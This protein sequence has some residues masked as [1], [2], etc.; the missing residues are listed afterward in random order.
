MKRIL[1][2]ALLTLGVAAAA[3]AQAPAKTTAPAPAAASSSVTEMKFF[4]IE[5]SVAMGYSIPDHTVQGGSSFI[6]N[7]AVADNM[8]LGIQALNL[9]GV[10]RTTMKFGYYLNDLLGFS[11]TF[12]GDT[13]DAYFGAG[14][15][16]T[17]LK[18]APEGALANAVKIRLEYLFP[19]TG[20]G[21]GVI[22]MT[23]GF[24]LGL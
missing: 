1:A 4:S 5:S 20:I 24:A 3:F 23:A 15:F 12:G 13:T 16:V 22:Y 2:I 10:M 8:A 19:S 11:A 6:L 17:L 7:F 18:N 14:A 21:N 9:G